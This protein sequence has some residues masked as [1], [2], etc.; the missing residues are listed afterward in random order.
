MEV[1]RQTCQACGSIDHRNILVRD[2]KN[3]TLVFVRCSQC[4]ELVARYELDGYY[5]HGKSA[6]AFTRVQ[7]IEEPESARSYLRTFEDT[8]SDALDGYE[9]ALETLRQ[10]DKDV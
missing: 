4:K 5:H 1:H 6:D 9:T 8:K 3:R 10:A 7:P 2:E